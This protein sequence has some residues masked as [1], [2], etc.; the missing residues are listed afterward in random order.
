M[1][2]EHRDFNLLLDVVRQG[3]AAAKVVTILIAALAGIASAVGWI[4][5]HIR[6]Q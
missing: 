1:D 4:I 6:M 2:V 5:D 3:K